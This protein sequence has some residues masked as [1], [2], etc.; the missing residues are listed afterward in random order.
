MQV[1]PAYYS[2]VAGQ[3][4]NIL[5]NEDGFYWESNGAIFSDRYT[6]DESF[7]TQAEAIEDAVEFLASEYD[8]LLPDMEGLVSFLY[9]I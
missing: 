3:D 8:S 1:L 5:R 2:P 6:S 9:E 4:F 7:E